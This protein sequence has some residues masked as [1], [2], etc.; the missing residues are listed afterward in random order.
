MMRP[1]YEDWH[2]RDVEYSDRELILALEIRAHIR[3]EKARPKPQPATKKRTTAKN[4][5]Y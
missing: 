2:P 5:K 3:E 4:V 1:P